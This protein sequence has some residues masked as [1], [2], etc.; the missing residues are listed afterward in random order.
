MISNRKEMDAGPPNTAKYSVMD[1]KLFYVGVGDSC[2][3]VT[4]ISRRKDMTSPCS[5][6]KEVPVSHMVQL[7]SFVSDNVKGILGSSSDT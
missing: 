6:V 3:D 1:N 4:L 7:A 5:L 2:S